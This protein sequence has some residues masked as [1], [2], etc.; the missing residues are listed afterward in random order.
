MNLRFLVAYLD[1]LVQTGQTLAYNNMPLDRIHRERYHVRVPVREELDLAL[2]HLARE[3]S[4]EL[5]IP[6]ISNI[7]RIEESGQIVQLQL[8]DP[9]K[10]VVVETITQAAWTVN[11]GRV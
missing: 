10:R 1:S 11:D 8:L 4:K 5:G 9:E 2:A 7:L 6:I 3:A